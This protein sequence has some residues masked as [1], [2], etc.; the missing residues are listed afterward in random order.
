MAIVY[1]ININGEF[2]IGNTRAKYLSLRAAQHNW[3]LRNPNSKDYNNPLYKFCRKHLVEKIRCILIE[4]EIEEENRFIKEQE[5]MNI[6]KPTINE[7]KAF[8]TK[9]EKKEQ[10]KDYNKKKTTCSICS[11][12]MN[13]NCIN[14][15]IK[16]IHPQEP[17]PISA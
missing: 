17:H 9:E 5:Y 14:R 10:R 3:N 12:L 4:D 2:Y 13:K 16:N 6:I 1:K 7:R 11:K 8:Q 15:H